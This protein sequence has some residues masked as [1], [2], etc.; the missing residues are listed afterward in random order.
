MYFLYNL[1]ISIFFIIA[2]PYFLIRSVFAPRYR[3]GLKEKLGF[4]SRSKRLVLSNQPNIWLH[5]VSV[6]EILASLPLI[7]LIKKNCPEHQ[8]VVSTTTLTGQEIARKRISGVIIIYFPLDLLW[9]VSRVLNIIEPSVFLVAESEIWPNFFKQAYRHKIPIVLF[10]GRISNFSY[11]RYKKLG[12]FFRHVLSFISSFGMQTELDARRIISLGGE[13]RRVK[14]T[15]NTKFDALERL[16]ARETEMLKEEFKISDK[17]L[18]LVAGSTHPGEEEIILKCFLELKKEFT[19][20]R[21]IL[22]PR[23]LERLNEVE[24]IISHFG[25]SFLRRTQLAIDETRKAPLVFLLD[26]I[27]EL[28]K[29]YSLATVVFVGGSL[30]PKGGQNILEPVN[31]GKPTIF[32]HYISN[33]QEIA[34]L[35]ENSGIGFRIQNGTELCGKISLLLKDKQLR[36]DIK[37]KAGLIIDN[38]KGASVKNFEIIREYPVC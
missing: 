17:D 26:T 31:F 38:N 33:F 32:G 8:L 34:E 23:H 12:L 24:G 3:A 18:I 11:S 7:E 16:D 4:I 13:A 37:N 25:L 5:A 2:F 21:L 22:C 28:A 1:I 6:G 35:I 29:I 36:E 20:L 19:N 15:G 14:V 30:V 27:G 9:I 10:N